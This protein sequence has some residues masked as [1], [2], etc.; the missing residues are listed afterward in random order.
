[1]ASESEILQYLRK[2]DFIDVFTF[3]INSIDNLRNRST[4]LKNSVLQLNEKIEAAL[5]KLEE[6]PDVDPTD[7]EM[8][9]HVKDMHY[10]ELEVIQRVNILIELLAV[11]YHFN[12][13]NL[14]ELPRA[15]GN[16]DI[17]SRQLYAEFAY[18][19]SQTP[20]DIRK[21]LRYPKVEDFSELDSTEK[22]TLQRM[23]EISSQR[24]KLMF[25]AIFEFQERFRPI[26]NKYKHTL[27]ETT[28]V[29]GINKEARQ[30]QSQIYLRVKQ[31]DNFQTYIISAGSETTKY[32]EKICGITYEVLRV[33]IDSALLHLANVGRNFIPRTVFV[34][35]PSNS[36]ASICSKIKSCRVPNFESMVIVRKPEPEIMDKMNAELL[37]NHIYLMNKDIMNPNNM[38]KEGIKLEGKTEAYVKDEKPT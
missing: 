36:Y 38:L 37:K 17:S 1:M 13:T 4:L 33:T 19:K 32:L 7:K 2:N 9:A 26:Y 34:D 15:I 20:E 22:E 3:L 6:N 35:D 31:N 12:R 8:S 23:L 27:S 25:N 14:K 16:K 28:G 5:R 11:H 30:L 21:N 10:A 18:F 29:Y 24:I